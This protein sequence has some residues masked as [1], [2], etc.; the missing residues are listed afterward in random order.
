MDETLE[1]LKSGIR[2]FRAEAYPAMAGHYQEAARTPQEPHTL[3]ITC[4]DSRIDPERVT[5]SSPGELFVNRNVGNLV[6]PYGEMLGS[7]SAVIEYAVAALKVRHIVVCGHSDCGAMKAILAPEQMRNLPTVRH[8]LR[9][10]EAA[11]MVADTEHSD[12][13]TPLQVLRRLTERNV[14]QQLHH[15]MT[16]PSVAA[17]AARGALTL[18]GW[19]YDIGSGEVR[20]AESGSQQFVPVVPG[21]GAPR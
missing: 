1:K 16:H 4:A 14:L 12:S 15:L 19:V 5:S 13:D 6:P 21:A 8:W 20:I 18:S 7:V 11:K 17:A 3:L 2:R 10:A 9:S